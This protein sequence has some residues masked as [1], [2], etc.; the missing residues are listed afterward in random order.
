MKP[1]ET[2]TNSSTG[3]EKDDDLFTA[4]ALERGLIPPDEYAVE[5]YVE[6]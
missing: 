4:I 3:D 5:A 1:E 6:K 2:V